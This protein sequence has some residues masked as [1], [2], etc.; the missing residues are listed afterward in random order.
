MRHT[1][2]LVLL[3]LTLSL[4]LSEANSTQR[5]AEAGDENPVR[6]TSAGWPS[7]ERPVLPAV[8]PVPL[9]RPAPPDRNSQKSDPERSPNAPIPG[10][11]TLAAPQATTSTSWLTVKQETFEG[12][13][14]N[15]GGFPGACWT[16]AG[17]AIDTAGNPRQYLWDDNDWRPHT[18]SWAAWPAAG[19]TDAVDPQSSNYL[20]NMNSWMY[21]GPLDL[22]AVTSAQVSF[23]LWRDIEPGYDK[24]WFGVKDE[25]QW[26]GSYSWDDIVGWEEEVTDLTP[27]VGRDKVWLMFGFQSD[28][29]N[30]YGGPWVDDIT[31][32][33]LPGE[34]TS[35]GSLKYANRSNIVPA[36]LIA[37]PSVNI[38]L[39]DWNPSSGTGRRLASSFT[40]SDGSFSFDPRLD[41]YLVWES[42]TSNDTEARRVVLNPAYFGLFDQ[43][44]QWTSSTHDNVPNGVGGS[45]DFYNT[46]MPDGYTNLRAMWLLQ[47][48]TRGREYVLSHTN[49]VAEPGVS[50][51]YWGDRVLEFNMCKSGSCFFAG[52]NPPYIFVRDDQI[53]SEDTP[54]HELGHHYMFTA[55]GGMNGGYWNA[56]QD[57]WGHTYF[58]S[59]NAGCA[60]SEGWADFFALAVNG[61]P[62]YD[63]D[64]VAN[65]PCAG[66]PDS[67]YYNTETHSRTDNCAVSTCGDAVEGR[68]A[69]ALWDFYDS[70][71]DGFDVVN[72]G[73][74]PIWSKMACPHGVTDLRAYWNAWTLDRHNSVKALFQNTI[75]FDS[76]PSWNPP[77]LIVLRN[78][79]LT[80]DIWPYVSDTDSQD[81]QLTFPG[82]AN[83][84]TQC[85]AGL[86]GHMLTFTPNLNYVG[87]CSAR[88]DASD[89]IKTSSGTFN[90]TV[91][92]YGVY[93]PLIM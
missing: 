2:R 17:D 33:A 91:V 71:S 62:C 25:T 82:F 57:C 84:N 54:E 29:S 64:T 75:D 51:A 61:N 46:S 85:A 73:F 45:A 55:T 63:F 23:W 53:R 49:P 12:P 83:L 52:T 36:P 87:T 90:A 20:P 15:C 72:H 79:S 56:S 32:I 34:V 14:P 3:S 19:G 38:Y 37:A 16:L 11:Q 86:A 39:Y 70:T 60:W 24:F 76:P 43:V 27:Y 65:A 18:G 9:S 44:Y 5:G 67:D 13:F 47:D 42:D 58:T 6:A 40:R 10:E 78:H 41:L 66:A 81:S 48:M 74:A 68:V 30:E 26:L 28:D 88:V 35:R 7:Y 77:F 31:F 50:R 93:C 92:I 69:G 22:R 21:Y 80:I 8:L 59:T 4:A 1:L 89:G